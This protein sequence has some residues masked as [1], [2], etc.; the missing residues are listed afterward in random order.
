MNSFKQI[1]HQVANDAKLHVRYTTLE[2]T[3]SLVQVCLNVGHHGPF[4]GS[5]TN[6][7]IAENAAAE[8]SLDEMDSRNPMMDLYVRVASV[9]AVG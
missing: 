2:K 9:C 7:R 6:Q 8:K 4:Y 3:C 1:M 5:G